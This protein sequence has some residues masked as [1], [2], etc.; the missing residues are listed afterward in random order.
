MQVP[1]TAALGSEGDPGDVLGAGC[2]V[3]MDVEDVLHGGTTEAGGGG[4]HRV[5]G[6]AVVVEDR[7]RQGCEGGVERLQLLVGGEPAQAAALGMTD[8]ELDERVGQAII[9][10]GVGEFGPGIDLLG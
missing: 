6:P 1:K 3:E 10:I 8:E 4:V 2:V 5:G 9:W 7:A